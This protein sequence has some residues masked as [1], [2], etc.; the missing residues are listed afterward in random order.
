M[1]HGTQR[2]SHQAKRTAWEVML[3]DVDPDDEPDSVDEICSTLDMALLAG[4]VPWA[5][6]TSRNG[7]CE[8][9]AKSEGASTR[10]PGTRKQKKEKE[11]A[12]RMIAGR[13]GHSSQC[14]FGLSLGSC[15]LQG[16][17]ERKPNKN[18]HAKTRGVSMLRKSRQIP[19][20]VRAPQ[21]DRRPTHLRHIPDR[22]CE[23]LP[24]RPADVTLR[25]GSERRREFSPG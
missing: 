21:R 20:D 8:Q 14:S 6:D 13:N 10:R 9:S 19:D 24:D 2:T 3:D 12:T 1:Y 15:R 7:G 23:R 25:R 4:S 17:D 11:N 16:P 5:S 22:L 18:S